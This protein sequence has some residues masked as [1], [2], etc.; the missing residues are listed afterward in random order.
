MVESEPFSEPLSIHDKKIVICVCSLLL[1]NV[2]RKSCVENKQLMKMVIYNWLLKNGKTI[3]FRRGDNLEL[4]WPCRHWAKVL[5]TQK[6]E[7][8]KGYAWL[9]VRV[10]VQVRVWI[11][12][13]E[14]EIL[15]ECVDVC[16][17]ESERE[18]RFV[19]CVGEILRLGLCMP[20]LW[21]FLLQA[22]NL[23]WAFE[24]KLWLVPPF[25]QEVLWKKKRGRNFNKSNNR[26]WRKVGYLLK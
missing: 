24:P 16:W 21:A 25:Q 13:R 23:A 9:S 2:P 6:R 3:M 20:R 12:E 19:L 26:R 18:H 4:L 7:R 1:V 17:W 5:D 15:I 14:K 8:E 11:R 22:Q 10:C